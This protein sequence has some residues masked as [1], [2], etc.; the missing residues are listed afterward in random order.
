M[1]RSLPLA[2]L[3]LASLCALVTV[4]ALLIVPTQAQADV[5]PSPLLFSTF[6]GG[7][8]ADWPH[9][10][11]VGADG[12][13]YVAGYTG[14]TNFPTTSG[15]Y[16]RTLAGG[17]DVYVAC[18]SEDG[19]TLE[20][21]TLLGG[22][23]EEMP[24]DIAVD[25]L[26]RAWVV[27]HTESSDFPTSW[28]APS[29]TLSGTRD[30]FV[31][32]LSADGST[33]E[34]STFLGG[35]AWERATA[36]ALAS[37]E[38]VWVAGETNSSFF[39]TTS[40]AYDRTL[41]GV[42]DAFVAHIDHG[43]FASAT[44]LGG[45]D[46]E[47]E[48]AVAVDTDGR[49]CVVL[50]TSSP[51]ISPRGGYDATHNG[52]RDAY[53]ARLSTD[54]ATVDLGTF[55]GGLGSDVPRSLVFGPSGEWL[56]AG[57]TFSPDLPTTAGAFGQY[58]WGVADGMVISLSADLVSLELC[59][60]IGGSN[61]DVA[62]AAY[63]GEDGH[64]V[65]A[66]YTN[67]TDFP[68]T[69]DAFDSI[70]TIDDHDMFLMEAAPGGANVSYSTYI[71]GFKG[72]YAMDM[73]PDRY[74]VPVIIAYSHSAD[75]PMGR[76][77]F[78]RAF[79]GDGDAVVLKFSRDVEGPWLYLPGPD[80]TRPVTGLQC[81]LGVTA[82]DASGID[83][84]WAEYWF[85]QGEV[86]MVELHRISSPDGWPGF[87][88]DVEV[89]AN[90]I[91]LHIFYYA[92]D[93]VGLENSTGDVTLD[94][95]DGILPWL[96]E[97]RT[98]AITTTGGEVV[99]L[100][101]LAD[102]IGLGAVNLEH[103]QGAMSP[104]NVTMAEDPGRPGNYTVAVTASNTTLEPLTYRFVFQDLADQWNRT[105]FRGIEVKDDDAPVLETL[106]GPAYVEP[107]ADVRITVDVHDNIGVVSA[108]A[109]YT[110]DGVNFVDQPYEPVT[111]DTIV[112]EL[113][114]PEEERLDLFV[115]FLAL[116]AAGNEG[117][118]T[119][120]LPN[121]D[122]TP[123]E[124][125]LV[126]VVNR[127]TTGGQVTLSIAAYDEWGIGMLWVRWWFDEGLQQLHESPGTTELEWTIDVPLDS[128]APL[129]Y[130]FGA[131][132]RSALQVETPVF[133]V[134]VV[135]DRA[136]IANAG[137][138]VKAEAGEPAVVGSEGSSDNIGI[139]RFEWL[140]E[141]ET[142]ERPRVVLGPLLNVTFTK[143][144]DHK[145]R[146][147]VYDAANNSA[148]DW[149]TITVEA[150]GTDGGIPGAVL[151][152]AVGIVVVVVLAVLFIVLKGRKGKGS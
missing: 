101:R 129:H 34:F 91:K 16:R 152:A 128:V 139:V 31:M 140:F 70:K 110:F 104:R 56:V 77:A 118:A 73:S 150:D 18:I 76:A 141:D 4:A 132:D 63:L 62:R 86:M 87:A 61:F 26:G 25:A 38:D 39:P 88:A 37:P 55:V 145:V 13:V 17:F 107:S 113:E 114:V 23:D 42:R 71:G 65:V 53:L 60:Y 120:Q 143:A 151:Y 108:L 46:E 115:E 137:A 109:R 119:L 69:S 90:A 59:T 81:S 117:R 20:W 82:L 149:V 147:T 36:V 97:D 29:T 21:A 9:A 105:A 131:R 112:L 58:F 134:E 7:F 123:P 40:G 80:F 106:S 43:A 100:V 67:S 32:R 122:H 68:T 74:G 44:L 142:E 78:D 33:V 138:D 116:D 30:A 48:P 85:D 83:G 8:G 96:V 22:K 57:Y 148:V 28:G 99:F 3:E 2:S 75:F 121:E 6:L 12:R 41:G 127:T 111:E 35:E 50:S 135:D 66:G 133:D 103:R 126:S 136:P 93:G 24:W 124:L 89:P 64:I 15:A 130:M 125:E 102:N 47:Q 11:D 84:V 19:S 144:G 14:S 27:G 98:Q 1:P 72:D 49:P 92:R 10:V 79:N 95:R 146:L 94:V 52:A 51:D 5:P 54:L 45:S